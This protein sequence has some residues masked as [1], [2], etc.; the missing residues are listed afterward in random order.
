MWLRVGQPI[1][2][3][4]VGW[5][6][7]PLGSSSSSQEEVR[8]WLTGLPETTKNMKQW[9]S[10]HWAAGNKEQRSPK[11]NKHMRRSTRAPSCCHER[12]SR[13]RAGRRIQAESELRRR[14]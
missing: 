6:L 2:R 3:C 1:H 8:H 5:D 9:L 7:Q 12:V 4:T 13:P 14:D 11:H 10:M